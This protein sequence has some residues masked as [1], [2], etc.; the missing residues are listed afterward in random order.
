MSDDSVK[1]GHDY[2]SPGFATV[3][4]D[5]A[6]PN[7][8]LGDKS[9]PTWP[10][11]RRWVDHKW[12]VDRR[13]PQIGFANRDEASILYNTA[14]RFK[15]QP[16]LEIG[17]W[18]GWSAVHLAL[19][20]VSLDVIDPMFRDDA[21]KQG[22]ADSCAAAGVGERVRL[23]AGASPGA[24]QELAAARS[25]PWSLIFIDGDHEGDAP[26]L[27]AEIVMRYAP[28]DAMVLFHDLASPYVS[29]GLDAMRNAG[30]QT[31]VY[32]TMQIMGVAW[33]GNVTPVEHVPDP[34]IF[35]TLPRHL[36]GYTVS[37]WQRPAAPMG[38]TVEDQRRAA[39]LRAQ[40]AEDE[41]FAARIEREK[42]VRHIRALEQ[43]Y[44]TLR[45]EKDAVQA[46][47][48]TMEAALAAL[49]TKS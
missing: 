39:L 47:A 28:A 6:F 38:N 8:I 41:F 31:M 9:S 32:Q 19:G 27:D 46:T 14:L 3:A 18:R 42:A 40:A 11:F 49:V 34:E 35:W 2:V 5:E 29:A 17:C 26:R 48:K 36:S 24:V 45:A 15:G 12:Y 16:C 37:G 22:V 23:H 20:G 4:P 44:N 43:A 25:Q 7:M 10:F 30:W 33:R 1:A 21:F 13:N